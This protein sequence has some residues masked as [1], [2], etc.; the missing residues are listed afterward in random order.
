MAIGAGALA[1]RAGLS[2]PFHGK[3]GPRPTQVWLSATETDKLNLKIAT[4]ALQPHLDELRDCYDS[5]AGVE[6]DEVRGMLRL[7]L[8][9]NGRVSRADVLFARL[10]PK[11]SECLKSTALQWTLPSSGMLSWWDVSFRIV[12]DPASH[13]PS[14]LG[15]PQGDESISWATRARM[16][17]DRFSPTLESCAVRALENDRSF[18]LGKVALGL[19]VSATGEIEAVQ[20]DRF[21]GTNV[22]D[23]LEVNST[24][25]VLPAPG[26]ASHLD[27]TV[28]LDGARARLHERLKNQ[29]EPQAH[30]YVEDHLSRLLSCSAQAE[31]PPSRVKLTLHVDA[32]GR[33]ESATPDLDGPLAECLSDRAQT[34]VFSAPRDPMELVVPLAFGSDE[35]DRVLRAP[36]ALVTDPRDASLVDRVIDENLAQIRYCHE[37]QPKA[38]GQVIVRFTIAP[39]GDVSS[40]QVV[41][42]T[43]SNPVLTACVT[44][45]VK[46]WRF[47]RPKGGSSVT[48]ARTFVFASGD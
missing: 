43:A 42:D 38:G 36:R 37:L 6:W 48:V 4:A 22:G 44:D 23:C 13:L 20:L 35:I 16:Q 8:D 33:V 10:H 12:G 39:T 46:T 30:R 34:L 9:A 28:D 31:A 7:I 2:P 32:E 47:A 25:Y 11:L 24:A 18:P 27:V 3:P 19:S 26:T 29:W 17:F 1:S 15:D 41:A 40:L 21:V 45:R 5:K 14:L